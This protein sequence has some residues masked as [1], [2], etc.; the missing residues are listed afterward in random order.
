MDNTSALSL[1]ELFA[2][3]AAPA[4]WMSWGCA[5]LGGYLFGSIPFGLVLARMGGYGDI[6]KIGSGNI[7]ATN[8]LRTGN[9]PLALATLLLD[10]GKG[11]IAVWLTLWLLPLALGVEGSVILSA[12]AIGGLGAIIGHCYPIW[13]GFKGGKGVATAMGMLLIAPWWPVGIAAG[14]TWLVS[15]ALFRI[16]S[17]SA[18]ISI[19]AAPLYALLLGEVFLIP[20]TIALGLLIFWRHRENIDRLRRGEEPKIGKKKKTEEPEEDEHATGTPVDS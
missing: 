9:K 8:V 16:S 12:A 19:A 17:L 4:Q 3:P 20:T 18:L 15:A 1:T 5:L 11:A 13:L 7:G 6:R 14:L 10:A 2:L